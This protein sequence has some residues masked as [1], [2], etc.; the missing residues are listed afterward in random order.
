MDERFLAQLD[1]LRGA[2]G[3]P[4]S[5]NS[6]Y[7]CDMHEAEVGGSG[8]NHPKGMAADISFRYS[9]DYWKAVRVIPALGFTGMG[10]KI[11][12][13]FEGRYIHVDTTHN[14]F[15]VWTYS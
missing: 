9:E 4:I 8:V 13:A 15:T 7:R 14:T 11:H 5:I 6:A 2:L 3:H 1:A 12:G 10:L